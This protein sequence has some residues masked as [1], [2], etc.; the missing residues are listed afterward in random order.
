MHSLTVTIQVEVDAPTE[1]DANE[2]IM[3]T[4]G[5]AGDIHVISTVIKPTKK[6]K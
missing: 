2:I 5:S 4:F 1:F 6:S 3:D